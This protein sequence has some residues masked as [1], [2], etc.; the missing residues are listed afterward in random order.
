MKH[1]L[2][3]VLALAVLCLKSS[4]IQ[5]SP[6]DRADDVE[7]V[8]KGVDDLL[9]AAWK[10]EGLTPSPRSGDAE[11]YRRLSIDLT[12][13]I[14]DAVDALA[15]IRSADADKR[16]K[17]IDRL[18][19]SEDYAKYM[20]LVYGTRLLGRDVTN[21]VQRAALRE[22]PD[23]L[24]GVFAANMPYRA[25]VAEVL[26]ARGASTENGDTGY[27]ARWSNPPED[28][29]Q[30]MAGQSMRL[31]MGIRLQCAQCHDHKSE[32][33]KQ[34]DFW[35]VAAFF[36]RTKTRPIPGEDGK[37]I[38]LNVME[39]PR[40][41]VRLP[42]TE[43]IVVPRFIQGTTPKLTAD[44]DRRQTLSTLLTSPDNLQLSRAFVNWLWSHFFGPGFV[45]PVDDFRDS[46]PPVH[47]EVLD[48]LAKDFHEH[49]TDIRRLIRIITR[50]RAYQLSSTVSKD[51]VRDREH[52]SRSLARP[53]S[54][55]QL[56][57]SLAEAAGVQDVLKG[58][59][60]RGKKEREPSDPFL[61]QALNKFTF[62]FDNDEMGESLDFEGTITQAL[63]L[64]NS[65][66]STDL[67]RAPG[68][69]LSGI[70]AKHK[71]PADR[72]DAMY[73]STFS[74]PA[75]DSEKRR[76]MAY[77]QKKGDRI[78]T[79]HDLFWALLNSTEFFFNH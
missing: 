27:I 36:A 17:A 15:F 2:L 25:L 5:A 64:M 18:V 43:L 12:G 6:P 20:A 77:L 16:D 75:A 41:N 59:M 70:L 1:L 19:E 24:Q 47:P 50:T 57:Y 65:R 72:I 74:R 58:K 42:D 76:A 21:Q 40:G 68:G 67:L 79:Y 14:P 37:P 28:A 30:N 31:F 7:K 60:G 26:T 38:G 44:D 55:E 3:A 4:A 54:P 51:N 71:S 53:M 34:K 9:A 46:N 22:F 45:N 10:A 62:I 63:F 32:P 56:F 8:V 61:R 23:W 78:E 73:L 33:W 52:F 13:M 69:T 35:G 48:L 11:F 66:Y 29:P 49:G 39:V